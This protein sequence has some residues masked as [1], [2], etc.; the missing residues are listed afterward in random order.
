MDL[1][2]WSVVMLLGGVG[3]VCLEAFVPSG[4]ILGILAALCFIGAIVVAFM[5]NAQTGYIMMG[6]TTLIVPAVIAAVIH[7]W[8]HTPIGK[9]ILI[10]PPEH[11]DD[12]LPDIAEFRDLKLLVGRRGRSTT[13]MLPGGT[14]SID[15]HTYEAMSLGMPIEENMPVEVVEVRMNRLVVRPSA[16]LDDEPNVTNSSRSADDILSRPIDSLGLEDPLA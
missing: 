10:Q 2:I 9:R 7:W 6:L 15:R 3:I 5:K 12:V 4:G 8:P 13:K 16:R 14:I 1:W 11:P